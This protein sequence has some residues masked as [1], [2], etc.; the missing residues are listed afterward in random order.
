MRY[1]RK[2][3][4]GHQSLKRT[5]ETAGAGAAQG[6]WGASIEATCAGLFM[7]RLPHALLGLQAQPLPLHIGLKPPQAQQVS[8]LLCLLVKQE[9]N[10]LSPLS[11]LC[12]LL[13]L[14]EPSRAARPRRT[15][16]AP[17]RPDAEE[18]KQLWEK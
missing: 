4:A 3:P 11:L 7:A 15:P 14:R 9:H 8:A 12:P 16:S 10:T 13:H 5:V 1:T 18:V 2:K 17:Q 6:I